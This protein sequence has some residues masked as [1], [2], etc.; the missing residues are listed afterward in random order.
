MTD[1]ERFLGAFLRGENPAWPDDQD[2]TLAASVIERATQHGVLSL[3]HERLTRDPDSGKG[4]PQTILP[5]CHAGVLTQAM[6]E[7]HHRA[8][9]QEVFSTLAAVGIRPVIFKGTALAY[10]LYR[11]GTLRS[12]SDTDFI[13]PPHARA[14]VADTLI[15]LGFERQTGQT[16]NSVSY[17]ASFARTESGGSVHL[18]DVHWR[19]NNSELLSRLFTHEELLRHAQ[20]VPELGPDAFGAGP[21]HALLLA[22]MHRATHKHNPYYVEGVVS[23]S[24]DRLIWLYDIHLLSCSFDHADWNEFVRQAAQKGLCH[25]CFDGLNRAHGAFDTSP[26]QGVLDALAQSGKDEVLARYFEGSE[27]RQRWMDFVALPGLARKLGFIGETLFPPASYMRWKYPEAQ[28]SPLPWLYL[29]R[30]ATGLVKRL[31]RADRTP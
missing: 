30:A 12:R 29:K 13:I 19:I 24:G 18:L 22:C 10:T 5:A 14:L 25:V 1:I 15:R 7:L 4:W 27:A 9:L 26:P 16:G 31:Q 6:W 23:Y 28:A 21:V 2:G 8:L 3:L 17:Q 11:K 20:P